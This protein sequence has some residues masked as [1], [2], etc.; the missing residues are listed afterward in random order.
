MT[1]PVPMMI[2]F[3]DGPMAGEVL[4]VPH[5]T[6]YYRFQRPP[7]NISVTFDPSEFVNLETLTYH[8]VRNGDG[9]YA[10]RINGGATY[11]LFSC[12]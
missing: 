11:F 8:L 6:E 7:A 2:K 3:I 10:C 5:F 9:T 4:V 12:H 1:E